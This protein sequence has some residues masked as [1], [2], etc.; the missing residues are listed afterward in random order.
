MSKIEVIIILLLYYI[1][2]NIIKTINFLKII[3]IL[4]NTPKNHLK[5][6]F[7]FWILK[8]YNFLYNVNF[9]NGF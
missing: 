7:S 1:Y 3:L 4:K 8:I 9:Q 5:Y 6:N 2:N